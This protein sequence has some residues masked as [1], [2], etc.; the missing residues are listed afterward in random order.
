MKA[1]LQLIFALMKLSQCIDVDTDSALEDLAEKLNQVRRFSFD[2]EYDCFRRYYGFT[3]FLLSIYDG[4]YVYL[5]DTKRITNFSPLW[6]VMKDPGIQ[7]VLYSGSEDLA[8]LHSMGCEFRNIFDVQVCAYFA[9]HEARGLSDLIAAETGRKLNKDAQLSDWSKRPLTREQREYAANDVNTLLE[10]ADKLSRRVHDVGLESAMAEE[11]C[12]LENI[13]PRD[14]TPKLKPNYY[15]EK[16]AEYCRVLL[17]AYVW[18]DHYARSRNVP[19]HYIIS[20]E[21]LEQYLFLKTSITKISLKGFHPSILK[22]DEAMD[23]LN[24]IRNTYD[25]NKMDMV[26]RIRAT[27]SFIIS[28]TTENERIEK[29]YN[30][31]RDRLISQ[32]GEVTCAYLLRNVKKLA[33]NP[34]L[35]RGGLRLYQAKI[36][37]EMLSLD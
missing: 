18:R 22:S 36:L 30:P 17:A 34:S 20:N 14:F 15:R 25:V 5:I 28:R 3:L 26:P 23:E 32:Y 1:L 2:T 31:I 8:L 7:K 33:V 12:C 37:Q 16:T 21:L 27:H 4:E 9:N 19:P 29:L 24:R 11:F 13:T 10:I 6:K 35:D